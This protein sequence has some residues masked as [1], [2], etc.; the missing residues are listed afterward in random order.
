MLILA[1]L[2]YIYIPFLFWSLATNSFSLCHNF[3]FA[4]LNCISPLLIPT[5]SVCLL[6]SWLE[7]CYGNSDLKEELKN[8]LFL[9]QQAL[10]PFIQLIP[11]SFPLSS[12]L[13]KT[14]IHTHR[15]L[16]THVQKQT[17]TFLHFFERGHQTKEEVSDLFGLWDSWDSKRAGQAECTTA[18]TKAKIWAWKDFW[19]TICR[20][21]RGKQCPVNNVC[22]G[23]GALLN[24]T[25]WISREN[26]L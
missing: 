24:G 15:H 21:R 18:V 23:D 10:S 7:G 25:L 20:L 26:I 4:S 3:C 6:S 8:Y 12:L 2:S 11:F 9:S 19:T 17:D 22:S 13:T 5:C 16:H 1:F 14:Q